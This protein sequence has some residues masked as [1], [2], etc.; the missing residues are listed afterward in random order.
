MFTK[1][2]YCFV[3][4]LFCTGFIERAKLIQQS[5]ISIFSYPISASVSD[6]LSSGE[7]SAPK[8]ACCA[9]ACS[10]VPTTTTAATSES[11]AHAV[12]LILSTLNGEKY[13]FYPTCSRCFS[14]AKLSFC[15]CRFRPVHLLTRRTEPSGLRRRLLAV[16]FGNTSTDISQV[17]WC[18][19]E[20]ARFDGRFQP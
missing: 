1:R 20:L 16:S 14:E 8:L 13:N 7:L 3:Q 9:I 6:R 11:T 5:E 18:S 17:A 10:L 4:P 2:V 19:L 15:L 12:R